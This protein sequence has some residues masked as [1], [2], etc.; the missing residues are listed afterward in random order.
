MNLHYANAIQVL[1][2][3][4]ALFGFICVV[5]G[6]MFVLIDALQESWIKGLLILIGPFATCGF[7]YA[8]VLYYTIW[9]Y[10]S[11]FKPWVILAF[12]G[13]FGIMGMGWAIYSA[14]TP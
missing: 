6:W 2:V 10:E 9:E 1:G 7:L 12:F 3:L 5:V 4:V 8:Y 13:G 11:K 14:A